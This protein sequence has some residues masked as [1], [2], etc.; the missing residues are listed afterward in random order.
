MAL[1]RAMLLLA[2]AVLLLLLSSSS[3]SSQSRRGVLGAA[4]DGA[5]GGKG[6]Y[7][8]VGEFIDCGVCEAAAKQINAAV[9]RA[10]EDRKSYEKNVSEETFQKLFEVR[11]RAPPHATNAARA[12]ATR[13]SSPS[14][15][16]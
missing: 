8:D 16:T 15:P 12:G 6:R 14:R 4:A 10:V 2:A 5:A 7:V 3:P 11:R 1:A 13:A 9:R